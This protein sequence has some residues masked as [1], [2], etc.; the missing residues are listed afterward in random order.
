M[1]THYIVGK[2]EAARFGGSM[3]ILGAPGIAVL[4]WG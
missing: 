3:L 1:A 2:T 4:L